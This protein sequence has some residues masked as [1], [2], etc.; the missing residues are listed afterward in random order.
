MVSDVLLALEMAMVRYNLD[1]PEHCTLTHF[2]ED[3]SE[4]PVP[5]F[6]ICLI[7]TFHTQHDTLVRPAA[8]QVHECCVLLC[9]FT[10]RAFHSDACHL[11][12]E[13][14]PAPLL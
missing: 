5:E 9:L 12:R 11:M 13:N 1:E 10:N 8:Q 4:L 14:A 7:D 6:L 3:E 2:A